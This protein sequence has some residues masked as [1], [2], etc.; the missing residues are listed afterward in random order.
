MSAAVAE[1]PSGGQRIALAVPETYMN[2]SGAAVGPLATRYIGG[3]AQRLI[4]VHDELDLEPGVVRI[5]VGG[6]TAGH[7]GLKSIDHY[8]GTLEFVRVRI[9]IGKP[10]GRTDGAR[11]VLA[12]PG[13]ADRG[14]LEVAMEIAADAIWMVFEEG[15]DAAMNKVNGQ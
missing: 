11:Y 6:G 12:R 7:N 3:E 8:L 5:K 14:V 13:K 1:I 15:A 9:G 4:V 2:E 10:P